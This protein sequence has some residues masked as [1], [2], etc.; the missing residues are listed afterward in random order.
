[1]PEVPD[2]AE[3][4]RPVI[5]PTESDG[6]PVQAAAPAP[7]QRSRWK[8]NLAFCGAVAGAIASGVYYLYARHFESTDDAQIDGDISAIGARVAGNVSAV[9]VVENQ[10]VKVGDLL[11]DLDPTD[12]QVAL[13]EARATLAQASAQLHADQPGVDITRT[14]SEVLTAT[15]ADDAGAARADLAGAQATMRQSEA[16]VAQARANRRL[17]MQDL[18][19]AR[20]LLANSA[21]ARSDLDQRAAA[22]DAADAAVAGA[23]QARAAAA[24][25]I[26]QA[27]AHLDASNSRATEARQ[28]GPR[29]V[30]SREA[31]LDIR[32]AN[33]EL[34]LAQVR[35][36]ELN[37]GYAKITAPVSGVIGKKTVH[38]GDRVQPGEELL[39]ISQIDRLWVTANFRETQLRHIRPGQ[40]AR[41]NV[42]ALGRAFTGSVE[43][44]GGATGA[45]YSLLPPENAT[46]NYVK[47]VQRLPVRIGFDA[48]QPGFDSLRPGLSVEPKVRIR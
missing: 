6:A 11:V 47:V 30:A 12:L 18:D 28:N 21:I 42:D 31:D 26:T 20:Q 44:V 17:A 33:V 43:S 16:Q 5:P 32:Q 38:V 14:S 19:R 46:G 35:Q 48:G 36:A 13:A 23:E 4:A 37:L 29:Q 3:P 40:R 39:A 25:R 15:A 34:S 7:R 1:M 24:Q 27:H 10:R 22:A 9:Y 8:R 41:V 2:V 45:R